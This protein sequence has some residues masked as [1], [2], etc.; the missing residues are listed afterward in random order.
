MSWI[1]VP[2]ADVR[3]RGDIMQFFG[4][5]YGDIVRVVQIGG[6]SGALNGYSMEL[7]A[8]THTRA[9]GEIGLFRIVAEAA[10]AAGV[11]RIE[12]IAGLQSYEASSRESERLKGL[13]AMLNS[14]IAEIEKKLDTVLARQKDLEKALKAAS[15]REAAGRAK[16]LVTKAQVL[17]GI[18]AII[19]NLGRA[20]GD[21]LQAVVDALRGRFQGVIVLA[22]NDDPNSVALVAAVTPDFT[23]RVQA[24]KLIQQI[25]PIVNGKGGGRP[26]N[27]RGGGKD[28]TKIDEALAEAKTL[29][30][31]VKR[32]IG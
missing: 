16:E 22:G 31:A 25:A 13:A 5:K 27:A 9:T 19:E 8:G 30:S 18:P 10:I 20:D 28:P 12:A 1:E 6:R 15:Q 26:D 14:P 32:N 2:Y 11:R 4:D 3:G 17:N 24:G 7:C 29:L 23:S 21:T